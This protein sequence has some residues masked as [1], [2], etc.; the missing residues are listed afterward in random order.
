[1]DS[2]P[3]PVR[4]RITDVM[5]NWLAI[6]SR[7]VDEA[8]KARHLKSRV[9]SRQLAFEIYSLAMGAHWGFQ[10]LDDKKA[11]DTIRATI[12]DR[13]RAL[14]TPS[15][16]KVGTRQSSSQHLAISIQPKKKQRSK[17]SATNV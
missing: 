4:D 12:L 6:L 1:F 9:D 8:R 13:I 3:G 16:P 17:L 2:R 7:A 11:L 5:K 14:A 15:C 10:L